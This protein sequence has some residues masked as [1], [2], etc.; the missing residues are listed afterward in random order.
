MSLA[1]LNK[2]IWEIEVDPVIWLL[3][4]VVF[5]RDAH[6]IIGEHFIKILLPAIRVS[7]IETKFL[8]FSFVLIVELYC[9]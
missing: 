9:I 8:Y 2:G 1:L 6:F 4:K 7:V 5:A 3:G